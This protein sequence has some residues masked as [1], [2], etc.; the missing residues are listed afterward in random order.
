MEILRA[1]TKM[2]FQGRELGETHKK[3]SELNINNVCVS[4]QQK[5]TEIIN[6]LSLK[7][8]KS[9][10]SRRGTGVNESD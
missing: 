6:L 5:F 9:W 10:S 4:V 8:L 3:N 7:K 2:L 1:K